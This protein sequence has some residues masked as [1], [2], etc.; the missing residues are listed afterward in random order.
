MKARTLSLA[1]VVLGLLPT[2]IMGTAGTARA[3]EE[4]HVGRYHFLVGFGDEPAYAGLKNSVALILSDADEKPVTD[5]GDSLEV[6]VIFGDQK[7][8]L[9]LEPNFEVG[10]FGTP[11]DYR[12]WF[13]PTRPGA[14]TFHF[15]GSVGNQEVD[16]SFS[17]SPATFSEV[18]DPAQVE[19]PVKDPTV[20]QVAQRIDREVPRLG[21]AIAAQRSSAKKNADSAKNVAYIG[22]GVGAL[23]V[24]LAIV[25]LA[26]RGRRPGGG[27]PERASTTSATERE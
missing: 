1:G 13:F 7:M 12:A 25:A 19:F 26:R 15:F 18:S 20:A 4:R 22:I 24:I 6:E 14:Y 5:L 17:S 11:G 16:E 10:E 9:A 21:S 2:L 3:H 23:G 27:R 8:E